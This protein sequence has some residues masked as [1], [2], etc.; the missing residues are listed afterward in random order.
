M[1]NLLGYKEKEPLTSSTLP[2]ELRLFIK[3]MHLCY[4]EGATSPVVLIMAINAM[5]ENTFFHAIVPALSGDTSVESPGHLYIC[6]TRAGDPALRKHW[7]INVLLPTLIKNDENFKPVVSFLLFKVE[8]SN[9]SHCVL[10]G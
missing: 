4:A 3:W 6:K 7:F 2:D 1:C 10:T 8:V 9:F 5:P